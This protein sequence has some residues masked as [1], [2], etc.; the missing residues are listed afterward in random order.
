MGLSIV[1]K[2]WNTRFAL[3]LARKVSSEA[4]R[5]DA[6]HHRSDALSS[7]MVLIGVGGSYAGYLWLDGAVGIILAIFIFWAGISIAKNS[8]NDILG[9]APDP[10]DLEHIK[11]LAL[12]VDG[13]KG[14]HDIIVHNYGN[15]KVVSLHIE[16]SHTMTLDKAHTL[17]EEVEEL[18]GREMDYFT[19]VH[20]DPL[21]LEDPRIQRLAALLNQILSRTPIKL[22]NIHDIRLLKGDV[23]KNLSFDLVPVDA[24]C[25]EKS[26]KLEEF[27]LEEVKKEFPEISKVFIQFEPLFTN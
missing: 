24:L 1:L 18:V 15:Q 7:I 13:V 17:S 6:Y 20:V 27:F 8:M 26:R 3:F 9:K 16:V 14:V 5:A 19:T 12:S 22:K 4:L 25:Q 23:G 2:E 11:A 10:L 21:D